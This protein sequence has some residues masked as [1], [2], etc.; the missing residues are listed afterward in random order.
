MLDEWGIPI[1][2]VVEEDTTT[3]KPK[4]KNAFE[5]INSCFNKRFFATQT[6]AESIQEYLFLQ[7][8]SN[9]AGTIPIAN[10]VNVHNIPSDQVYNFVYKSIP[11]GAIKY[12]PYPKKSKVEDVD[13]IENI[14]KFYKCSVKIGNR[15][16]ELLPQEEIDKINNI[17]REGGIV[18]GKMPKKKKGKK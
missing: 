15:Y 5:I 17:Y 4:K 12:I 16:A 18:G 14:C 8:L 11:A 6:E 7:I 9:H 3:T 2:K 13:S 10:F 1:T